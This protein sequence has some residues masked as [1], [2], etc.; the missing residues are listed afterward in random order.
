MDDASLEAFGRWI[1][2]AKVS[3]L[4]PLLYRRA[5]NGEGRCGNNYFLELHSGYWAARGGA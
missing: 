4:A 2:R 3:S 5:H 1:T